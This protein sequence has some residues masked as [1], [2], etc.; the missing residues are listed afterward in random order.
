[1]SDT[2]S[3]IR[4]TSIFA[5]LPDD[6][7]AFIASYGQEIQLKRGEMLFKQD[8][9]AQSFYVVCSGKVSV[10]IPALYGPPLIVQELSEGEVLGWSW[11]IKPYKWAFSARAG[12]DAQLI[13]FDGAKVLQHCE[14]DQAFGYRILKLFT[15]LMSE[16]LAAAR[17]QMM[18]SWAAPGAA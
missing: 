1:M 14:E 13:A 10:E 17:L 5:N 15:Q 8:D 4:K 11:L 7:V 12:S 16:R 3:I 18:E 9:T 6:D 2:K